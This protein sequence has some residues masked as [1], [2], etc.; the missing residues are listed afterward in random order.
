MRAILLM[1]GAVAT[2]A[3]IGVVASGA[4]ADPPATVNGTFEIPAAT[5]NVTLVRTAGGNL[6]FHEVAPLINGGGIT[7]TALDVDNF[8][9][10]AD[11]SFEGGGV[12]TC[13]SCTLAGRTGSY[14]AVFTFKGSGNNYTGLFHF[15]GGGG[16]AGL[17]GGGGTF[18]SNSPGVGTF[19]Y[20]YF[21]S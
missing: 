15:T 12:E 5:D 8:V 20:Q 17:H 18:A 10:H 7:G 4:A 19:S 6:F 2:A 9:V 14:T 1:M 21:F 16:L 11:G 3:L 13:D